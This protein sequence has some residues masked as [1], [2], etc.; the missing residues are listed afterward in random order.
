MFN[1]TESNQEKI[2]TLCLV[3]TRKQ[4]DVNSLNSTFAMGYLLVEDMTFDSDV[5]R[6]TCGNNR[7]T[8]REKIEED[9]FYQAPNP[10]PLI[11]SRAPYEQ[12]Y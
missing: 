8:A 6:V 10:S 12:N 4:Q 5:R 2:K 1:I 7:E 11:I 9:W 3:Y